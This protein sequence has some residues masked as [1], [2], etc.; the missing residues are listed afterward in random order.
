[1]E[2]MAEGIRDLYQEMKT[3]S[4]V[5]FGDMRA[6]FER[7]GWWVPSGGAWKEDLEELLRERGWPV[8]KKEKE[9]ENEWETDTDTDE[10][11]NEGEEIEIEIAESNADDGDDEDSGGDHARID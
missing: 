10:G 8:E 1:M 3:P 9:K 2:F 11:E 4:G 7:E 5:L 6:V